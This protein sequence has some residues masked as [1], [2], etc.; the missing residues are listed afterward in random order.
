M[1]KDQKETAREFQSKYII[2]INFAIIFQFEGGIWT[3]L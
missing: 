1:L 2:F 3:V